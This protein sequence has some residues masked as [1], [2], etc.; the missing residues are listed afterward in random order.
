VWYI[1]KNYFIF[2]F[3]YVLAFTNIHKK[4]NY[5]EIKHKWVVSKNHLKYSGDDE[6]S[7]TPEETKQI[8]F[9][10]LKYEFEE[11]KNRNCGE[12]NEIYEIE[13]LDR[14]YFKLIQKIKKLDKNLKPDSFPNEELNKNITPLFISKEWSS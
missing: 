3:S 4:N 6:N 2:L 12:V 13:E 11:L 10:E 7:K 8:T 9:E 5:N 1:T 14:E